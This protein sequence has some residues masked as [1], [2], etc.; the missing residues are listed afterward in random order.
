MDK[1][2]CVYYHKNII[3]GKMYIGQTCEQVEQRWKKG[4]GYRKCRLFFKAI[5]KYGWDNFEHGI[6]KNNLTLDEANYWEQYYIRYYHTWVQDPQCNGYNLRSGGNN[7]LLSEE[8][9]KKIS[10]SKKGSRNYNYGQH[11]SQD[12]KNLLSEVMKEKWQNPE[13]REMMIKAKKGHIV[14]ERTRKKISE[15]NKGKIRSEEYKKNMSK[16]KK[17]KGGR[18]VKCVNTGDIFNTLVSAAK[19][20]NLSDASSISKCC[21]KTRKTAGKHPITGEKLLWEYYDQ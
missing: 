12:T 21:R 5:E 6:L 2:F 15:A 3:N 11:L 4:Y 18:K 19:W 7:S 1:T 20:S 13:Y 14:S 9:K 17:G 10:E 16:I 8:T